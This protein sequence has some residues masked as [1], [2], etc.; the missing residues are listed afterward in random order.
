MDVKHRDDD[1]EAQVTCT[2]VV[3]CQTSK[4]QD[5]EVPKSLRLNV[6]KYFTY[7]ADSC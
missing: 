6:Y 5:F 2:C 1:K 3:H 7:L 4:V